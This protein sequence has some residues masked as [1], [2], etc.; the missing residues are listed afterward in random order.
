MS[1]T[2]AHLRATFRPKVPN[3]PILI[4]PNSGF[5]EVTETEV[6]EAIDD[7]AKLFV[8]KDLGDGPTALEQ[9]AVRFLMESYF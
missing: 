8:R 5:I 1:K 9:L 6:Q 4:R 2:V 7:I 3:G